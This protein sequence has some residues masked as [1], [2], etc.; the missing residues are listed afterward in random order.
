V[1]ALAPPDL[2]RKA[3]LQG[4]RRHLRGRFDLRALL[5]RGTAVRA[6]SAA[7]THEPRCAPRAR[8]A[9]ALRSSVWA[10]AAGARRPVPRTASPPG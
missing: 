7:R 6:R 2:P 3:G 10:C 9:T 5:L 1:P 4:A 8:A